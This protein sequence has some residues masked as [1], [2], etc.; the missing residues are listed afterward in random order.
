M[1]LI[2]V[3][4]PQPEVAAG[5]CY[6]STDLAVSPQQ[7]EAV[8]H[9]LHALL[10]TLPATVALYSSPLRRCADLASQLHAQRPECTLAFD[11]RL[12]EM[13][14]GAWEMRAWDDIPRQQI[15]DWAADLINYRPGGGENVL[16]MT[17]RV[18]DFYGTIQRQ[19]HDAVVICHAGT[20]RLMAALH[21]GLPPPEAALQAARAPLSIAYGASLI[22]E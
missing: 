5:I 9:A 8:L 3:R 14:F 18:A 4:H 11:P 7:R 17:A 2:L 21:D 13:D 12:V 19:R 22:L 15:D 10:A 1:K 16:T 20:I 6:G